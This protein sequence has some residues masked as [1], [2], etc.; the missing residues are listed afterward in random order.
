MK[1]EF[2]V[3]DMVVID[4]SLDRKGL[5]LELRSAENKYLY[6][7]PRLVVHPDDIAI[8]L[9]VCEESNTVLIITSNC[10][11]GWIES[12]ALHVVSSVNA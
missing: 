6:A 11:R 1:P 5:Y 12:F 7:V 10:M 2:Y 9:D 8:V 4:P 3:G